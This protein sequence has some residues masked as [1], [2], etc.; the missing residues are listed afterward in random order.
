MHSRPMHMLGT[1]TYMHMHTCIHAHALYCM[2]THMPNTGRLQM[3]TMDAA[4]RPRTGRVRVVQYH[5]E[6]IST[7][8]FVSLIF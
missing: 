6:V 3:D 7:S 5:V 4:S 8:C 1:H 2:S